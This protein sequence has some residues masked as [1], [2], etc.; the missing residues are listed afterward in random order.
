MISAILLAAGQSRRMGTFKQ[1]L[2]FGGKTFVECCV[3]N[4][5][6]S[7]VTDVLVVTGHNSSEVIAAVADRRVRFAFNPD[8]ERGMASSIKRGIEAMLPNAQAA[9]I[10]LVDQPQIGSDIVDLLIS[11]YRQQ[12]AVITMPAYSGKGG[13]PI[14]ID[15]SLREEVLGMDLELGLRQVLQAHNHE[16]DR[17]ELCRE[18]VLTDFDYPED[19]ARLPG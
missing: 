7:G 12:R 16:T 14:L 3:D 15:M 13:H 4:L 5:L 19:Y 2:P 17:V 11:R 8:Y 9:L 18:E 6:G 1:L 10:A